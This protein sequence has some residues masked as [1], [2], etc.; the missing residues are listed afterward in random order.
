MICPKCESGNVI[1][2]DDSFSHEFGTEIIKYWLCEDCEKD[3]DYEGEDYEED[4]F[5]E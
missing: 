5:K 2:V 4:Y 3:W 1:L